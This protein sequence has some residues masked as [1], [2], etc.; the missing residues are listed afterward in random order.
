MEG[1]LGKLSQ[2]DATKTI[3]AAYT[4]SL[5]GIKDIKSPWS[6]KALKTALD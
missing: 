6:T 2:W 4:C 1:S 3:N 5:Q